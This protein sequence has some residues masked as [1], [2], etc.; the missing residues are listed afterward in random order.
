SF[1]HST[2]VLIQVKNQ[3][4]LLVLA[5]GISVHGQAL[6][7]LDPANGKLLWWCRGAGDAASPA[8]GAG[9]VY[10]DSGR[11]G[12]G[13]AVDPS[14]SG[15]VS[16][17]HTRWTINQVPEGISS[18]IIIGQQ[19]YRLHTPGILKCWDAGSGSL[20]YAERLEGISTTWASPVV[21]ADG[22]LFF[23]NAG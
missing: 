12:S 22:R 20:V 23:A 7:S 2:P 19:V 16:Q 9:L 18:P 21:D 1:G 4:Q 11:G 3:P 8:F 13:F 14:G 15:D 17:T 5:S 6:R 10:F